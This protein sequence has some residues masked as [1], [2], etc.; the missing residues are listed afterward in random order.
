MAVVWLQP[1]PETSISGVWLQLHQ[2]KKHPRLFH[3]SHHKAHRLPS[4][5]LPCS[6][7][8]AMAKRHRCPLLAPQPPPE[9]L[10]SC[11]VPAIKARPQPSTQEHHPATAVFS[12]QQCTCQPRTESTA[13]NRSHTHQF[14][15]LICSNGANPLKDVKTPQASL[16]TIL[17][18]P[19]PQEVSGK[20]FLAA[21]REISMGLNPMDVRIW[22]M[23]EPEAGAE[24]HRAGT[25]DC[26]QLAGLQLVSQKHRVFQELDTQ[27]R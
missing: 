12:H 18:I 9:A 6:D 19:P 4:A 24:V 17:D 11:P 7:S 25:A 14:A 8:S 3:N 22:A 5:L 23:G 13:P 16:L 26:V 2:E 1:T 15:L 10:P 21:K 20:R 27:T